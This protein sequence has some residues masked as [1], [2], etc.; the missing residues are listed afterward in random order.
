MISLT[1]PGPN[2]PSKMLSKP[3]TKKKR[4]EVNA[5][6]HVYHQDDMTAAKTQRQTAKTKH[7]VNS[8][9]LLQNPAFTQENPSLKEPLFYVLK[10][11]EHK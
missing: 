6:W 1:S 5:R 4:R 2:K 9:V 3:V 8:S 7:F 11:E 10:G